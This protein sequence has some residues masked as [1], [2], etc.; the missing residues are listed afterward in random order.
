MTLKANPDAQT[1]CKIDLLACLFTSR[2]KANLCKKMLSN[3]NM[4]GYM[5]VGFFHNNEL[6][7]ARQRI[8]KSLA[9]FFKLTF[10]TSHIIQN[11]YL[12]LAV[13]FLLFSLWLIKC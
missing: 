6:F 7:H 8:L 13:L 5:A 9:N 10:V 3:I 4:L 12:I 11:L 2:P 1:E